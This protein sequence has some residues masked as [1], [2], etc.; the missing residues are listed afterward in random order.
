[1]SCP[2]CGHL[3]SNENE[4]GKFCALCGT[5]LS[6]IDSRE[7]AATGEFATGE[8]ANFSGL[9]PAGSTKSSGEAAWQQVK[10]SQAF[11]QSAQISKQ[12]GGFF[13][14][15]LL[16][17]YATFK[18]IGNA[19]Y[20]NG[21]ITMVIL[22][23]LLPLVFYIPSLRS[24]LPDAFGPGYLRPFFL[25][26]LAFA[27]TTGSSYGVIRLSGISADIRDIAA[28]LGAL[29]V[30]STAALLL[31]DIF[32]IFG[33]GAGISGM[34]LLITILAF[35]GAVTILVIHELR[36]GSGRLD[37]FY[38]ALIINVIF[39]Y[40]LFRIALVSFGYIIGS[41]F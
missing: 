36:K 33:F 40:F 6:T 13:L 10:Q 38:G 2:K 21:I 14:G 29:L 23:L 27:V 22:S 34:F 15:A 25:V 24:F 17:P 5:P 19:H 9:P 16:H 12:Y 30:P 39:G 7:V 1:M 28:K 31:C 11:Q 4:A 8:S 26:L 35:F 3:V 41:L 20:L 18:K 32:L 37:P